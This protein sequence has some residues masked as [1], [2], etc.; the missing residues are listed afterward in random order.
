[1]AVRNRE[2]KR[3]SDDNNDDVVLRGVKAIQAHLKRAHKLKVTPKVIYTWLESSPQQLP[4]FKMTG[5]WTTTA[6][7]LRR[8]FGGDGA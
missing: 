6:G 5:Q 8:H 1:M 7:R 2:L 4:A 3:V